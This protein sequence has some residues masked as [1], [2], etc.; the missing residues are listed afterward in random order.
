MIGR[1]FSSLI[2]EIATHRCPKGGRVDKLD[3]P[4][5]HHGLAICHDPH[6]GRDAGV[7]EELLR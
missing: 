2:P 7:I 5:A 3:F 4:F 1:D 6:I